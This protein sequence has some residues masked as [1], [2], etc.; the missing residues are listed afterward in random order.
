MVKG[1]HQQARKGF[2]DAQHGKGEGQ[3]ALQLGDLHR[4]APVRV[5]LLEK[6]KG[7]RVCARR[8]AAARSSVG[9]R[10][11]SE[12]DEH[13]LGHDWKGIQYPFLRKRKGRGR[14]EK[15]GRRKER[16]KKEEEKKR[17]GKEEGGGR[18]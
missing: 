6:L 15:E 9:V 10:D 1:A 17:G 8:Q 14:K 7:R 16:K 4:V 11:C 3:A 2:R 5:H 13:K 18:G 12:W